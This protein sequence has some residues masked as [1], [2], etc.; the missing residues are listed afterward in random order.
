MADAS[1]G[2]LMGQQK[3]GMVIVNLP[4]RR[5][6]GRRSNEKS[7]PLLVCEVPEARLSVYD[8]TS[9]LIEVNFNTKA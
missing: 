1:T 2:G 3:D 6:L 8:K 5:N 9:S 7:S 4:N